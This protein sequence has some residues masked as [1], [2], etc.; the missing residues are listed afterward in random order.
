MSQ[1]KQI[2]LMWRKAITKSQSSSSNYYSNTT[3]STEKQQNKI[4]YNA[5][6]PNLTYSN[7]AYS[8][9]ISQPSGNNMITVVGW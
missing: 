1:S 5:G 4:Y 9:S 2:A 3:Y 7:N 8:I 6:N